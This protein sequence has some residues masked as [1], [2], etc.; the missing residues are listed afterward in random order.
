MQAPIKSKITQGFL[1]RILKMEKSFTFETIFYIFLGIC[2]G[3]LM[4]G[5]DTSGLFFF[6]VIGLFGI[7]T[8]FIYWS[9][10][11][12]SDIVNRTI[13]QLELTDDEVI[14]TTANFTLFSFYTK[15]EIKLTVKKNEL[16]LKVTYYPLE[17]V[18][19][20]NGRVLKVMLYEKELYLLN[21]FFDQELHEILKGI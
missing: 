18:F 5:R 8:F 11:R 21:G 10:F 14:F 3:L 12:T 16:N 20:Y 15:K 6:W 9:A 7:I 13:V 4:W 1:E 19:N 2:V 17:K